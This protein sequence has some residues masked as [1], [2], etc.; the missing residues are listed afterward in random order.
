ME[1]I[2]FCLR[3]TVQG[4][5]SILQRGDF[6]IIRSRC[7]F[8]VGNLLFFIDITLPV[9]G[10]FVHLVGF[11]IGRHLRQVKNWVSGSE[12]AGGKLWD[13]LRVPMVSDGPLYPCQ[14]AF[15]GLPCSATRQC[16]RF[17]D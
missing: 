1:G 4:F 8:E 15:A 11:P 9:Y 10:N 3:Q 2:I 13:L 7:G 12:A 16:A 14:F 5:D 17:Y 6:G